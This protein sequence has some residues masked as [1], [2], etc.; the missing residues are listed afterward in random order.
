MFDG[1]PE[2]IQQLTS[3]ITDGHVLGDSKGSAEKPIEDLGIQKLVQQ[4][5]FASLIPRAWGLSN[6][7]FRPVILN[8]GKPC[9]SGNGVKEYVTDETAAKTFVCHE[10]QLYY[11][12][13]ATGD[14]RRCGATP[15]GS[16][17]CAFSKFKPLSGM[18]AL[19]AGT[20]GELTKT[21]LVIGAL[22]GYKANGNRNGW[23]AADPGQASTNSDIYD[24]TIQG[25]AIRSPG[26]VMIPICSP[27][28]A[29][30]NWNDMD[31]GAL[32]FPCQPQTRE[33][34]RAVARKRQ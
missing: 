1:S 26:V 33:K 5:I 10:E 22:A 14:Y 2:S 29:V 19:D 27:E 4:A 24:A 32:G 31:T 25:A 28:L 12:V 6:E 34:R 9:D 13:S 11:F 7:G 8:S 3:M 17:S 18:E 16:I 21:D 15:G 30:A 20:F 23:P